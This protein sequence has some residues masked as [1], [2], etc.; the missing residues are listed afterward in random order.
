[1]LPKLLE[2]PLDAGIERLGIQLEESKVNELAKHPAERWLSL[3]Y[4]LEFLARSP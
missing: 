3:R 2:S 4:N 1:M